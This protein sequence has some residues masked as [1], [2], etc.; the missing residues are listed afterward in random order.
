MKR[1]DFLKACGIG[2]LACFCSPLNA[3]AG[4]TYS[5]RELLNDYDQEAAKRRDLYLSMF[6][7]NRIDKVLKEMRDSYEALIPDIPYIG[8]TNFHL[9]WTI[10]NAEKLAEYL[11]AKEYGVTILEFSSL[12]IYNE[13]SILMA[14]PEA[15]RV[16][17]GSMQFGRLFEVGMQIEAAKSQLRLYPEEHVYTFVKGN[18]VDFDWGL[19][20]TQCA[21]V[22]LYNRHGATDLMYP[23]VCNMD[24]VPGKAMKGGYYRTMELATG[25]EICDL[26]WKQ[27]VESTIPDIYP[28][29]T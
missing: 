13:L 18:G 4:P 23:L 19:N 16:Q 8:Q 27:G 6:G 24:Y 21:N 15:F 17:S 5:L 3:Y 2:C 20:Y 1:R 25:G 26:R 7:A 12:H 9:Q 22:I 10:P 28:N 14:Q 11:V 29:P